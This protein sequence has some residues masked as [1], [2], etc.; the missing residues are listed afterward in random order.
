MSDRPYLKL[1]EFL[2]GHRRKAGVFCR[3]ADGVSYYLLGHILTGW[4]KC[5]NTAPKLPMLFQGD[6]DASPLRHFRRQ[7]FRL[8]DALIPNM[9]FHSFLG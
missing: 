4:L 3:R 6:E 2:D 8:G 9:A 1:R 5:T 7:L